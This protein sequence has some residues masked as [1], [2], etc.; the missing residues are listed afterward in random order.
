MLFVDKT[1]SLARQTFTNRLGKLSGSIHN[2]LFGAGNPHLD[3]EG[4]GPMQ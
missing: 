2:F 1:H 4:S 3:L